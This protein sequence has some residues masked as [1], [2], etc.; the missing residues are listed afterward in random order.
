MLATIDFSASEA[1]GGAEFIL[2]YYLAFLYSGKHLHEAR[3]AGDVHDARGRGGP[4]PMVGA[5]PETS[6]DHLRRF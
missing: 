1:L 4:E 6:M 5:V 3:G 2:I